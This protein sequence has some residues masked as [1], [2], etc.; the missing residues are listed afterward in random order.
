MPK[1]LRYHPIL[2]PDVVFELTYAD[3]EAINFD[4]PEKVVIVN[5]PDFESPKESFLKFRHSEKLVNLEI[6][7]SMLNQA[8]A[9][10]KMIVVENGEIVETFKE[11]PKIRVDLQGSIDLSLLK[12]EHALTA[13]KIIDEK[14]ILDKV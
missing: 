13:R 8:K 5:R 11:R 9:E 14:A 12:A 10:E 1:V 7:P 6:L 3:N 4:T 2:Q